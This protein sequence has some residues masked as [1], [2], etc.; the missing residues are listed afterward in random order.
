M[1]CTCMLFNYQHD[2]MYTVANI[3]CIHVYNNRQ[4]SM[5]PVR[6]DTSLCN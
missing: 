4:D 3:S 5:S 6:V 1:T 2:Y